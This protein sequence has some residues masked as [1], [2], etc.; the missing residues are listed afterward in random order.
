MARVLKVLVLE[1]DPDYADLVCLIL[2]N[3][4][5]DVS[6]AKDGARAVRLLETKMF[7][8]VILDWAV[9]VI[10]GLEVL[11]W[12]RRNTGYNVPVL[13]L[14]NRLF[15]Q[16]IVDALNAGADDY[17]VKPV[18]E[19]ALI[20]RINALTRRRSAGGA[21]QE[22]IAVG[23]YMLDCLGKGIYLKGERISVT[24]KE[25]DIALTLF[26]NL[27]SVVPRDHL[28]KLIW[29]KSGDMLSRS[30][31]THVYRIRAKL[32]LRPDNGVVL[33]SIY[34]VGYRLEK[35]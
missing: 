31:D 26:Q 32:F 18:S 16:D 12:V 4:G 22:T 20:A 9:P 14:T 13:F 27:G 7:D 33:K 25:F 8:L 1:D 6:H 34:T 3:H 11:H 21:Q 10:S 19:R 35:V 28:I 23:D 2:R 24:Q 29:G 15:E 17:V 5:H 30:L